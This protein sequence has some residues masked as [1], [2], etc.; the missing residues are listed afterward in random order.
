[1]SENTKHTPGPWRVHG[2]G[3][4]VGQQRGKGGQHVCRAFEVFMSRG[5]RQA[6]ARLIAVAPTMYEFV[7]KKAAAGDA[8]AIAI[9][10]AANLLATGTR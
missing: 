8:E 4:T 1:M 2:D 6:N 7:S 9:V 3:I 5:E 10:S